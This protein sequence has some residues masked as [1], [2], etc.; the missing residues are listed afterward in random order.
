MQSFAE[1]ALCTRLGGD[2]RA[3][4][5]ERPLVR[6]HR[7][8]TASR[9]DTPLF[10]SLALHPAKPRNSAGFCSYLLTNEEIGTTSNPTCSARRANTISVARV[11]I[12]ATAHIPDCAFS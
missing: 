6:T 3:I 12:Q 9:T 10:I 11:L 1:A 5:L 4:H 7:E 8:S 2:E